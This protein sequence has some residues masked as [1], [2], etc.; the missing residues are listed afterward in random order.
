MPFC[1]C[2]VY[3]WNKNI[4]MFSQ[5]PNLS[6]LIKINTFSKS[7]GSYTSLLVPISP[8]CVV[9]VRSRKLCKGIMWQG[10]LRVVHGSVSQ[11]QCVLGANVLTVNDQG[12]KPY[13]MFFRPSS[14]D[15]GEEWVCLHWVSCWNVT[16][17]K[18]ASQTLLGDACLK[19]LS[20]SW[21]FL[22][23]IGIACHSRHPVW[24]L[25]WWVCLRFNSQEESNW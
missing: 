11:W 16:Q 5:H 10:S 6:M 25:R 8:V 13:S 3:L 15:E 18:L 23:L 2:E 12:K 21:P 17:W 4:P 20:S 24:H 14:E 7:R 19:T 22:K 9:R 1:C